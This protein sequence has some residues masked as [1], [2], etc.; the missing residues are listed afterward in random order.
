MHAERFDALV[1]IAGC[2][3]S[4]PGM[5]MAMARLNLPSVYLYGGTILP[6]TYQ[7]RDV[8]IQD[9]F[10]AVGAHAKGT[11]DDDE[12]LERSSA[13]RARP[14]DRA[15]AC[16]RRTRWPRVGEALGMSL[17]GAASPPA[18]DYRREV[19]GAR[20][21]HRRDASCSRRD[22]RP[23]QIM[24]KEAFENAIAVVM[25]LAGS[26][27]AVLHLLAIAR[28]AHVDARRSTT[29][30]AISR[31]TPAPG[32]RSSGGQV[33][34]ERPRPRRRRARRDAGAA[35]PRAA[36]RR[37]PDR[38]RQDAWPRTWPTRA[39]QAPDGVVVHPADDADPPVGWHAILRGN[40]APDGARDEDRGRGG[41]GL[42]GHGP[43]VRLRARRRSTRSRPAAIVAGDVVVIRYEGPKGS[44][45]M[46]E[47][48]A[49]TAAVAGAGLGK[50]VALITDGRFSGATKGIQ[51]RAHRA[52]GVRRRSDRAAR[53]RRPDRDRRRRP[54]DRRRWSTTRSSNGAARSWTRARTEVHAG[55]AREVRAQLVGSRRHGGGDVVT[56][57]TIVTPA[58]AR[59]AGS[60]A[61]S[62]RSSRSRSARSASVRSSPPTTC[63]RSTARSFRKQ[64][65]AGPATLWRYEPLL[66]GGPGIE[67]V[68]LGAGFTPLRRA[69]NL[70][71]RLGLE[72]ALDQG[73]LGQPVELLQGPGG[74]RRDH[75]GARVRVRGDLLRLDRQPRER[76][77]RARGEGRHALLRVRARR[78]RA[79][80]DPRDRGVRREGR[81]REGQLRR[82]EPAVHRGRR[83]AAV[84]VRQREHAAVLRGG[85]EVARVRDRR[86]AR[87]A[88]A[89]P[90]RRA[91]R[92]AARCSRRST[93]RSSE[94]I[95]IGAVEEKPYRV[96]R[97]A[98]RGVLARSR[99]RSRTAPRGHADEARHDRPVARD[100]LARRRDVRDAG[101]ARD[102]RPR[103]S[104]APRTRSVDGIRLLAETEGVFTETA[105]GVTIANLK[106]M[107]E[108]G[109][110]KPDEETV[111]YV[112]G[113][114]Y[115]TIEAFEG[116]VEPTL[117]RGAR[118][119][120]VPRRRSTP[121]RVTVVPAAA[122]PS[123]ASTSV[124]AG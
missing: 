114:G 90:R 98:A 31:R 78:P 93:A 121:E 109:I 99:R 47:M 54:H 28:E 48:L 33:R 70:A 49:V 8:T 102:R 38:D 96:S 71:A 80:E 41:H 19:A 105:G 97:R 66:P 104:G 123:C 14:P 11:I 12:L 9:V 68:D 7:G 88:P 63:D 29:S 53:G 122:L 67:R 36:A 92:V 124:R 120:R 82:R 5:L 4:E 116:R 72:R 117:P 95:A 81:R 37:L 113:N 42:R 108:Q 103:S 15:P 58:G 110:V 34:D 89:R 17:P 106:R 111:A 50:D 119:R 45:G 26:T 32:R 85:L 51:R 91:D 83:G 77:R 27:N 21:R 69:D 25:A 118:P 52:G 43:V 6:G 65:E 64:V 101:G 46:P 44:P 75:D 100:R 35:R 87:L 39:P 30:T 13:P 22:L 74:H 94:L 79:R 60:A 112:T 18:V 107:C 40:V 20:D 56:P 61:R 10:E 115:K 59:S 76:D 84:G 24:T 23:R 62:T 16:T 1:G 55:R 3:K 57:P 73:R 86:A 2:D